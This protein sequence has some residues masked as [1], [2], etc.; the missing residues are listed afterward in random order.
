LAAIITSPDY[1]KATKVTSTISPNQI[2]GMLL[3]CG[4]YETSKIGTDEKFGDFMKT[5]LWS[6][7][8]D[9]NFVNNEYFKTASVLEFVTKDFPPTFISVGNDDPLEY[10]SVALADKLEKF[11]VEVDRFFFIKG[12]APKLGHEYQFNLATDAAKLA[13]NKSV[14]FMKSKTSIPKDTIPEL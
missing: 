4:P 7:S 5:V 11:G 1:A 14:A 13:L 3:Y 2:K 9:R 8:G 6:Y 12:Y 10:H